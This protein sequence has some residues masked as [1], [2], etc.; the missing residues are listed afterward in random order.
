AK[1]NQRITPLHLA[2]SKGFLSVAETLLAN[3]AD[4]NAE[5]SGT[6]IEP[7]HTD[8]GFG[9]PDAAYFAATPL[10]YAAGAGH[11]AIVRLLL[12]HKADVNAKSNGGLTP[13]FVAVE[14][15]RLEVAKLLLA[16]D[17]TPDAAAGDG[18]TALG[19]AVFHRNFEMVRLLLAAGADVNSRGAVLNDYTQG[20]PRRDLTPPLV[21]AA[22]AG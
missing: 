16:K 22:F 6:A 5:M 12:N 11:L 15:D 20:P 8:R 10:H 21:Y 14:Q 4:S 3:G 13:L 2:A 19:I 7:F 18:T 9:S 1:S 17:A